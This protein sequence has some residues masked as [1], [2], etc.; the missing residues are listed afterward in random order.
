MLTNSREDSY[1]SLSSSVT[2]LS[3]MTRESRNKSLV[4]DQNSVTKKIKVERL[5]QLAKKNDCVFPLVFL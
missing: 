5:P 2:P 3:K 1:T 4:E